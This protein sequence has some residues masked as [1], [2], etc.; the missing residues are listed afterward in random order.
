MSR[1]GKKPITIPKGVDVQ[2]AGSRKHSGGGRDL[3]PKSLHWKLMRSSKRAHCRFRPESCQASKWLPTWN[4]IG[5]FSANRLQD[6][7]PKW[8]NRRKAMETPLD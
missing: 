1:V 2:V 3:C 8:T 6:R 7:R 4:N 5:L